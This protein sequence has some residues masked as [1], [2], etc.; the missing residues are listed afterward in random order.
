VVADGPV[1]ADEP[2]EVYLDPR[3]ALAS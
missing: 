2:V 1:V 3:R